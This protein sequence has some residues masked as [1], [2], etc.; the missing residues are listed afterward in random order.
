MELAPRQS[1]A[2]RAI[3]ATLADHCGASTVALQ[4]HL[5]RQNLR[6]D[7]G[8]DDTPLPAPADN[9]IGRHQDAC[10]SICNRTESDAWGEADG[11][12]SDLLQLWSCGPCAQWLHDECPSEEARASLPERAMTEDELD[13]SPGWRCPEEKCTS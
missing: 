3:R 9:S 10:C 2:L 1:P 5:N 4:A 7:Y 11:R 13:T 8:L 6:Q 12:D